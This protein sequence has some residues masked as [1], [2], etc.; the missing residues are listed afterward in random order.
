MKRKLEL[1]DMVET[2]LLTL[3]DE[4]ER[5]ELLTL[6]NRL[7][8]APDGV[9]DSKPL[10][11]PDGNRHYMHWLNGDV[12]VFFTINGSEIEAKNLIRRDVIEAYV[13]NLREDL[14]PPYEKVRSD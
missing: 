10:D 12:C 3:R 14:K 1:S 9:I 2:Q 13:P 6:L 7:A 4:S 11:L 8:Q 5:E